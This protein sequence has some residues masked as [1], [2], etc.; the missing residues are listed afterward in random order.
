ALRTTGYFFFGFGGV[1]RGTS[2]PRVSELALN[3]LAVAPIQGTPKVA[4]QALAS[5]SRCGAVAV[6]VMN[7]SWFFFPRF[8]ENFVVY[9]P[10]AP[11]VGWAKIVGLADFGPLARAT[12]TFVPGWP[13]PFT[14]PPA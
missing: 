3:P 12:D 7:S 11:T 6:A 13:D 2:S 5:R 14:E 4:W 1:R 10:A 9:P 8:I